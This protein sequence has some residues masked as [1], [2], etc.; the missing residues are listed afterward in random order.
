MSEATQQELSKAEIT[1][2]LRA[3]GVNRAGVLLVHTSFRAI[4]P[5]EGGPLGLIEAI[6][7]AVGP[8]STLVMPSFSGNDDE[9]FD[10]ATTPASPDLGIVADKFWRLP[11]VLRSNHCHAFAAVRALRVRGHPRSAAA[12]AP[13]S[14]KPGRPRVRSRWPSA[15]SW[16]RP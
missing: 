13:Y 9:V 3:L 2:R 16:R 14:H 5:V 12:S 7:D 6:A 15:S 8:G 1:S 11:G 4:K 10:P